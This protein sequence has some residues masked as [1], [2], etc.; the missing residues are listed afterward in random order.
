MTRL[1]GAYDALQKTW[2][3]AT[4]PDSLIDA[5]QSGDRLSYH[6]ENAK[7]EME[8]DRMAIIDAEQAVD[9][10]R[11]DFAQRVNEFAKRMSQDTLRNIDLD[12]QKKARIDSMARAIKLAQ[13]ADR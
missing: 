13:A 8:H 2:P 5:M 1:R 4:P 11:P 3:V 10:M 7:A 12:Q 6:P 9:H